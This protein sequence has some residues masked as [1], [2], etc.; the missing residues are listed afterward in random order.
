[1]LNEAR[2]GLLLLSALTA[3]IV[4]ACGR[5]FK[6]ADPTDGSA[7]RMTAPR[8]AQAM[9]VLRSQTSQ[10]TWPISSSSKG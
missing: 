4:P 1:M 2:I 6:K 7:S 8:P 9:G 5:A 10:V 3:Q